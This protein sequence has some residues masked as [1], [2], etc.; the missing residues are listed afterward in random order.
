VR[1]SREIQFD[2]FRRF[3][4]DLP[5]ALVETLL[6]N[7]VMG[8]LSLDD[9]QTMVDAIQNVLTEFQEGMTRAIMSELRLGD[10]L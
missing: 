10:G 1:N 2:A 5:P 7:V 3:N 4:R 8:N 9:A 6:G